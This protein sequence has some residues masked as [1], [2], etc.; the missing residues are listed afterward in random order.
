MVQKSKILE[1]F[2]DLPDP[3]S[4]ELIFK[5]IVNGI[6]EVR[7]GETISE[8]ELDREIDSWFK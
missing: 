2:E 4:K 5:K 6:E 3:Y 7:N 1:T 8:E